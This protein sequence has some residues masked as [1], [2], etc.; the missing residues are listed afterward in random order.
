MSEWSD[1]KTNYADFG[2]ERLN[3]RF[4]HLVSRLGEKPSQSIPGACQGW[5]ETHAAYRFFDNEKVSFGKVLSSHS[6]TSLER[7]KNCQV[8]LLPQDTTEAIYTTESP[9]WHRND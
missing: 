1:E 7:I 5:A 8:V 9:L 2:D 6:Q 3:K 4:S